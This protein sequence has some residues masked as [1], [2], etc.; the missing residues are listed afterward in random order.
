M[1]EEVKE[2]EEEE[3]HWQIQAHSEKLPSINQEEHSH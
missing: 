2:E 3:T 1:E